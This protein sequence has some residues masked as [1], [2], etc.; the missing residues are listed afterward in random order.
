MPSI[1]VRATK[2]V[3]P[4]FPGWVECVLIDSEKQVHTF[5]EKVPVVMKEVMPLDEMNFPS[6]ASIRC[7]VLD[8]DDNEAVINTTKP[9]G[10]CSIGEI[11]VFRVHIEDIESCNDF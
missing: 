7:V 6:D 10:V 5:V 9:D 3:D 11:D 2:L 8:S 4:T 1:R